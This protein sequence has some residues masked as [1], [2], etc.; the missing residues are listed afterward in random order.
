MTDEKLNTDHIDDQEL[1]EIQAWAL[2]KR[3][4]DNADK[5]EAQNALRTF[6]QAV[7]FFILL[8]L[9]SLSLWVL[10]D[11]LTYSRR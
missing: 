11:L 3:A 9:Y 2:R 10:Y 4:E 7:F 6:A 8:A 5:R 1:A